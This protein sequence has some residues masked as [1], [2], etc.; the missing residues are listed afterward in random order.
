MCFYLYKYVIR[1]CYRINLLSFSF[2]IWKYYNL[3][4]LIANF[5]IKTFVILTMLSAFFERYALIGIAFSLA[6][7]V[8]SFIFAM[9]FLTKMRMNRTNIR[10]ISL[11]FFI[12]GIIS[13]IFAYYFD[14][15]Y[16]RS[17]GAE[18]LDHTKSFALLQIIAGG[19]AF[20]YSLINEDI[21]PPKG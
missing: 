12:I 5:F 14:V 17:F 7:F 4:V 9:L 20:V 6:T 21:Y 2:Q 15:P 18:E 16:Y 1:F 11:T 19:L 3:K 13:T 10:V 8:I